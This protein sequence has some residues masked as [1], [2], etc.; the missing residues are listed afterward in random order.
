[1]ENQG[2]F[3]RAV[4]AHIQSIRHP[5]GGTFSGHDT[6]KDQLIHLCVCDTYNSKRVTVGTQR[7]SCGGWTFSPTWGG[8]K[9]LCRHCGKMYF[10]KEYDRLEKVGLTPSQREDRRIYTMLL[11]G[12]DLREDKERDVLI[13]RNN[14][15]ILEGELP[16][17][18]AR[19]FV[20]QYSAAKI[21]V[22]RR[23]KIIA[24]RKTPWA[25]MPAV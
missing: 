6:G 4:S 21:V 9:F 17:E 1:M 7:C 10:E 14:M 8:A 24:A 16:M 15:G 20:K 23:K 3:T 5:S 12:G 2:V 13:L 11:A 22:D 18:F 19:H 25:V